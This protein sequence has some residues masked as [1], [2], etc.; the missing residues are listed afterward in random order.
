VDA[1]HFPRHTHRATHTHTHCACLLY[2]AIPLGH[3]ALAPGCC[4][5]RVRS[6]FSANCEEA[7]AL[8]GGRYLD[9]V[10]LSAY[11]TRLFKAADGSLTVRVASAAASAAA[12]AP[13]PVAAL[14]EKVH[15]FEGVAITVVMGDHGP[16]M[17]RVVRWLEAALPH[18]ANENQRQML[19]GYVRSFRDGSIEQHKEGSRHWIRDK[20]PVVES[21]IGFIE[22]Y[23]VTRHRTPPCTAAHRRA[24]P[25]TAAPA[26]LAVHLPRTAAPAVHVVKTMAVASQVVHR[27]APPRRYQHDSLAFHLIRRSRL[28]F[29]SYHVRLCLRLRL[30]L[31]KC[32]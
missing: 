21:Y 22:S 12:A 29:A 7:D 1:C 19:D 31:R 26:A 32:S 28:C 6:Y 14:C 11:N 13:D 25:R 8:L 15:S 10:S 23:V 30:C 5:Q 27:H 18:A 2:V 9:S 4:C 3:H 17:G 20:G 16:L 24:P